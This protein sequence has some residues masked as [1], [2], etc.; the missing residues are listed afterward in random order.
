MAEQTNLPEKTQEEQVTQLLN[1][2][3]NKEFAFYFFTLDT[4]GNPVAG[5]ANIYEHVKV[6]NELGYKAFI[7]HEKDDYKLRG[8][9]TSMGINDW[10]GEEYA[11][12]PHISIEGQQLNVTPTDFIIIPEVFANVMDQVKAFPCKKIVF[13][14]SYDYLLELLPI[15]KKWH[16]DFGFYDAFQPA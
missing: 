11:A 3:D 6:L 4:L 14:Q 10:L 1:Q 7:M 12:L 9:E 15:G 5:V 8:D 16:T 13:S 2:L